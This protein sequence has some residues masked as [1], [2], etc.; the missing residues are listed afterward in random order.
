MALVGKIQ[1]QT[2]TCEQRDVDR[3]GRIVAVCSVAGEDV[4]A[5]LVSQGLAIAYR[6]YSLEYVDEEETAAEAGLG[7]WRGEFVAPWEWRRGGR[8][9]GSALPLTQQSLQEH[10]EKH[11]HYRQYANGRPGNHLHF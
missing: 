5:W 7:M 11:I 6:K 4:G 9:S 2:V 10:E 3:Y 8:L 1:R